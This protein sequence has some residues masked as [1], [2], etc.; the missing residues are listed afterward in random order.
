[1]ISFLGL[2]FFKLVVLKSTSEVTLSVLLSCNVGSEPDII[3]ANN[4]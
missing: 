4:G 1:V 3:P 2:R